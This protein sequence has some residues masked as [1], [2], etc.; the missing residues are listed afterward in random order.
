MFRLRTSTKHRTATRSRYQ[1]PVLALLHVHIVAA[2]IPTSHIQVT[3]ISKDPPSSEAGNQQ[4]GL[5]F[6][7]ATPAIPRTEAANQKKYDGSQ[8]SMT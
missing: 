7:H 4:A 1:Y 2:P 6:D 5:R 3:M 8:C